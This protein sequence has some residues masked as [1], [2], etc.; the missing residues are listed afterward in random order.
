MCLLYLKPRLHSTTNLVA[1][2]SVKL[3]IVPDGEIVLFR[4][5]PRKGDRRMVG[6][7]NHTRVYIKLCQPNSYSKEKEWNTSY[8]RNINIEIKFDGVENLQS[9]RCPAP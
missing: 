5:S 7:W 3:K 6:C 2:V 8:M 9:T 1:E 4:P